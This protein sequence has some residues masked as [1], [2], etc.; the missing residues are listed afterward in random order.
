MVIV[1][2]AIAA[3]V[4]AILVAYLQARRVL[5]AQRETSRVRSVFSRYVSPMVLDELLER[6]DPRILTAK[7]SR[8]TII[9]CRIWNFALFAEQ[10]DHN[11]TLRYLNEFYT[12]AGRAIQK[13]RG[14]VD[15]FLGDG[16]SGVFGVPLEDPFQEEHALRASIE[17]VRLVSGMNLRWASQGR[18]P[19]RVG[20]AVN[21]GDVIAGEVGYMQRREYA[22][23]GLPAIVASRLQERTE[24]MSAFVLA[25]E[26]TLE[27]VQTM[28]STVPA[29]TVPLR[30]MKRNEKC[31]VVRGLAKDEQEEELWL[32]PPQAFAKTRIAETVDV[33]EEKPEVPEP[34]TVVST[35]KWIS[36]EPVTPS[37]TPIVE[38]PEIRGF[39]AYDDAPALP[40]P[41]PLEGYYED[42]SGRPPFKLST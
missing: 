41:P 42:D 18:K 10:L 38:V 30:G 29:G 7:Q 23:V 28:F 20:V 24:P 15:K 8:A 21:S 37:G 4:A 39:R 25:T 13:H 34:E 27:P 3:A 6:R 1:L 16:V 19:L 26:S 32:P 40:D 2:L 31:F 36:D 9:V 33:P 35:R 22:V 12:L 11:E 14:M 17:I 5:A